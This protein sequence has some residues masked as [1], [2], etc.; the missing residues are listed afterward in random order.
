MW[1]IVLF[2]AYTALVYISL[3]AIWLML[4]AIINP[5]AFLPYATSA[6]TFVTIISKK[7]KDFK[8]LSENG[9]KKLEEYLTKIS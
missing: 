4:G 3:V 8:D 2:A 1:C 7:L 5:D 9:F 6:A